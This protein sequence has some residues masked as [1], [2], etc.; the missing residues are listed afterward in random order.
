MDRREDHLSGSVNAR[1]KGI[2]EAIADLRRDLVASADASTSGEAS[3]P[4]RA[5]GGNGRPGRE[6]PED[7]SA[8]RE[9][10]AVR[11]RARTNLERPGS[12]SIERRAVLGRETGRETGREV[13]ALRAEIEIL[14]ARLQ[15]QVAEAEALRRSE[16]REIKTLA[17]GREQ[18]LRRSHATRLAETRKTAERRLLRL[19]AQRRADVATLSGNYAKELSKARAA[20]RDRLAGLEEKAAGLELRLDTEA[21]IYSGRLKELESRREQERLAAEEQDS[22][23][24]EEHAEVERRLEDRVA[25]LE[26]A[27]GEHEALRSSLLEELRYVKIRTEGR[28]SRDVARTAAEARLQPPEYP[29]R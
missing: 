28:E 21:E 26:E 9:E 14:E 8:L 18:A 4:A 24:R 1:I 29:G 19:Q 7:I 10:F 22:R 6:A 11:R 23:L 3:G 2:E 16:V 12:Y 5:A 20:L 15:E 13:E 17:E 25:E 27:V